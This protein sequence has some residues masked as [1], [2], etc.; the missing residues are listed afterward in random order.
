MGR[1][2]VPLP[3]ITSRRAGTDAAPPA[4][5]PPG[6]GQAGVYRA[7]GKP[8]PMTTALPGSGEEDSGSLTGAVLARG[9][10]DRPDPGSRGRTV[11]IVLA[12]AGVVVVLGLFGL[13]VAEATGDVVSTLFDGLLN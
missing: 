3:Q 6:G 10:A 1:A 7:S 12:I 9:R 11:F 2:T 5:A 4:T 8:E 13:V